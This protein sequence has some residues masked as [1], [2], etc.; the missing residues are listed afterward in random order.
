MKNKPV[1][2]SEEKL[3]NTGEKQF[4]FKAREWVHE[5]LS[6]TCLKSPRTQGQLEA[7]RGLRF[8]AW[9][10]SQVLTMEVKW[11]EK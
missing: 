9:G 7:M 3:V 2:K 8:V 11:E 5:G 6:A 10:L 1:K 4:V